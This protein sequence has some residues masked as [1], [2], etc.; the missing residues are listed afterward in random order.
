M[1]LA[2]VMVFGVILSLSACGEAPEAYGSGACDYLNTRDTTAR[3]IKY[4]E[5]CVKDFG[6]IVVLLDATTAPKTVENFIKLA[7]EGFYDGLTF[8]RII[9]GFMIQG[10]DPEGTGAGGADTEIKGEFSSNGH[11]NDIK[12][13]RG[14][15][16]MARATSP[17]SASSQFFICHETAAH[18]DGDYAAFGYVVQGM[19]VVDDI[20][21]K[22]L[23]NYYAYCGGDMNAFYYWLYYGNGSLTDSKGNPI[24]SLQPEIRYVKVLDSWENNQKAE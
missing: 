15:I 21:D 22:T 10:G 23:E 11:Y 3:D 17:D 16:S 6:K 19:S 13:Y 4:V 20:V 1:I 14:V 5:I 7:E 18:L 12:H 8:H 9:N 24:K 2:L